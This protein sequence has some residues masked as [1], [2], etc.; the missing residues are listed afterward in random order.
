VSNED[1]QPTSLSL[2]REGGL[3]D[4]QIGLEVDRDRRADH[5]ALN[6]AAGFV[7]ALVLGSQVA[8]A[9]NVEDISLSGGQVALVALSISCPS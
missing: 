2:G 5:V 6:I 1:E 4:A 8:G 3:D 7:L 9:T